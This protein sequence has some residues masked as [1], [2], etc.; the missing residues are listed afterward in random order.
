MGRVTGPWSWSLAIEL[1]FDSLLFHTEP[2]EAVQEFVGPGYALLFEMICLPGDV[3][4]MVVVLAV[5]R[6]LWGRETCYLLLGAIIVGTLVKQVMTMSFDV[7]RPEGPDIVVYHDIE[8]G[9]FPSGHVFVATVAWGMFWALGL[10]PLWLPLTI[11][12]AVAVGRLY[13]GVHYV[14][15]VVAGIVLAV[16]VIFAWRFAWH[17]LRP[18]LGGVPLKLWVAVAAM[19]VGGAALT[20][21]ITPENARRWE[22]VGF[23]L[24]TALAL[25]ADHQW[26]RVAPVQGAS[27]RALALTSG[28]AGVAGFIYLDLTV[29]QGAVV[30]NGALAMLVCLW[31]LLAAPAIFDR[32]GWSA[33][34]HVTAREVESR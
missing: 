33:P 13:L 6:W 17:R 1:P 10:M 5:G 4:G 32:L 22:I 12:V 3:W 28:L 20:L 18:R 24:G 2:I 29:A 30:L 14:A 8:L 34:T 15:D 21:W 7:P 19:A 25:L 31:A 9:S 11:A 16:P 23:A 27:R 26:L